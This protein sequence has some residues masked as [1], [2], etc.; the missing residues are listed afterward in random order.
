M[1]TT[2]VHQSLETPTETKMQEHVYQKSLSDINEL[3]QY[4]I[5]T[6]SAISTASLIK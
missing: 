6:W 3:K 4:V 5:E 2:R 1:K